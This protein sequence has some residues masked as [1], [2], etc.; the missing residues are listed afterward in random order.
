MLARCPSCRNTFSTDRPGR[1]QC[2]VCGK[3]LVVPEQAPAAPSTPE[4]APAV[5]ESGGTP[6]E[7]RQELGVLRAWAETIQQALFEPSRLFRSANI[8]RGSAHLGFAILTASVFW[9]LGQLLDRFLLAG[10]REQMMRFLEQITG[11]HIPPL[12]RQMLETQNKLN[13]PG[14]TVAL[15]LFTPVASFLLLYLNAAVTHLFALLLGQAK[16]GF[17]ATFAACA[18]AC[19]PLVLMA[20]PGCGSLIASV[21]LIVLT[22]IGLKETHRITPGGAAASVLGPYALFCCLILA[23]TFTLA[24]T[25]KQSMGQP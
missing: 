21:W 20:I 6:W 8:E 19:A 18:Y 11:G 15:T 9:S 2:P 3:P 14:M 22:G 16:R 7:R 12:A 25:M 10:Q 1:Q 23:A 4:P 17:S 5:A 13:T 24:M